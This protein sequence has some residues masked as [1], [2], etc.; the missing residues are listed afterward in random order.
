MT[1]PE[2]SILEEQAGDAGAGLDGAAGSGEKDRRKSIRLITTKSRARDFSGEKTA[3]LPPGARVTD[4]SGSGL[5][6]VFD[7]P[8]GDEFP[9]QPG[10]GLG[11]ALKIEKSREV[12][13]VVASVRWVRPGGEA[14]EA[15]CVGVGLE[16]RELDEKVAEKLRRDLLHMAFGDLDTA[17]SAKGSGRKRGRAAST[18]RRKK[19]DTEIH[20]RRKLFLGEILVQQGVLDAERLKQFLDNE[21]S[22]EKPLGRELAERGL[23]DDQNVAKALAEQL[24]LPYVNLAETPPELELAAKLPRD[25][26]EKHGCLPLREEQGRILVAVSLRPTL[27]MVEDLKAGLGRKLRLGIASESDMT[28]WRSRVYTLPYWGL[29]TREFLEE[30]DLARAR[31]LA[32]SEGAT[33]ESALIAE[34]R[35]PKQEILKVLGEYYGCSAFEFDPYAPLPKA[36]N[37]YVFDRYEQLKAMGAVPVAFAQDQITVVMADLW[38]TVARRKINTIFHD[39]RVDY[40]VGLTDDINAAVDR[41]F[42]IE[43]GQTSVGD[44][45]QELSESHVGGGWEGDFDDDHDAIHKDDSAIVKLLNHIIEDACAK[46]ASDVHIEPTLHGDA[47]VRYRIDGVLHKTMNFPGQYRSAIISRIK[48]MSDLD[49]AERRKPQS[50]KIRFKRWGRLDVEL[51]VEILPSVG[52]VEDAVLRILSAGTARALDDIDLSEHNLWQM[53]KLVGMPYG[54]MLCVGPTGSGKTTTLH[55]A[56]G[57]INSEDIKILTAE[58][59]VEITQPGLRQVQINPKAGITFASALRSFLRADPDVIMIGEMRDKETAGTAVEASMTG[60]LVMSTLHTNSAPET[61]VRLLELGIDPYSFADALLGVLAQRLVRTLCS[62]CRVSGPMGAEMRA[63]L[64]GE[65]GDD[66]RFEALGA[67]PESVLY[68]PPEKRCDECH[69]S[70]YRGRMAV[71]ELLSVSDAI[72]DH[73]YKRDTASH[74]RRTAMDEG[75]RTLKQDGIEKVLL[76]ATTIE[77]V[78]A[79]CSR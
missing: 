23:V 35:I 12:F 54:L 51:R 67:L 79:V 4:I 42:G 43:S 76:G 33:I 72:R 38:D 9:L 36:L 61:I 44:I 28:M 8:N 62:W 18:K 45:L 69:G 32:R 73:I 11:F 74:I 75:M 39:R 15:G 65:Y 57:Y 78:R 27:Q 24:R 49:I 50:G 17:A 29:V 71:H 70:G 46:G 7:W 77:E 48:V 53:K 66:D 55:S 13:E 26:F 2:E 64:R 47:T 34:F 14:G 5:Q 60:H 31:S 19:G 59:P 3:Q 58:D 16:L 6:L 37:P 1:S 22:G 30:E 25:I 68:S 63:S 20:V 21:F 56:L 41:L 52:G 10:D 40:R